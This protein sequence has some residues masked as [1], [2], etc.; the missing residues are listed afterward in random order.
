M[1]RMNR[2]NWV[3]TF[4]TALTLADAAWAGGGGAAAGMIVFFG[5]TVGGTAFLLWGRST[6]PQLARSSDR[7]VAENTVWRTF[8]VGL[9]NVIVGFL[10]VAMLGK[11]G[12][13]LGALALVVLAGILVVTFRGALGVWPQ[14][15]QKVLGSE[16]APSD[17]LAVLVAGGMLTGML[18][19]FPFGMFFLAYVLIRSLGAGMLLMVRPAEAPAPR[20]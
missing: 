18:F 14:Y 12:K 2:G 6:F 7:I 20:S 9:V 11:L 3:L 13:P 16:E 5:L 8:W 10:L 15:G 19:L 4:L 17:I 1:S